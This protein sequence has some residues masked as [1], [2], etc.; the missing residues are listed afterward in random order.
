[1]YFSYELTGIYYHTPEITPSGVQG[2][3]RFDKNS[4]KVD[5]FSPE[6]EVRAVIEG[7]FLAKL[8][9]ARSLGY[10]ITS[11]SRV[12]ATGG[13]AVNKE[14]LQVSMMNLQSFH[15]CLCSNRKVYQLV[16]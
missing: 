14:I 6:V 16:T 2:I 11:S 1:M 10:E 7:Q 9:H 15:S 4:T 8:S 5:S 12:L 3:Y 13:G